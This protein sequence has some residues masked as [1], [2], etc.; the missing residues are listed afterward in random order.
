MVTNGRLN[1]TGNQG[2]V[3]RL[4]AGRGSQRKKRHKYAK[5][6]RGCNTCR[7]TG[8]RQEAHRIFGDKLDGTGKALDME[9]TQEGTGTHLGRNKG[10]L[11]TETLRNLGSL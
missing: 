2:G 1:L 6:P 9:I 8:C 4:V 5:I 3:E 10:N 11:A 7:D